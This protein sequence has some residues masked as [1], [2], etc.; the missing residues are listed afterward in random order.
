MQQT[1]VDYSD[2]EGGKK[3]M[4]TV[5]S[6]ASKKKTAAAETFEWDIYL[7]GAEAAMAGKH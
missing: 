4:S 5:I 1:R 2:P 7:F 3:A 6:S